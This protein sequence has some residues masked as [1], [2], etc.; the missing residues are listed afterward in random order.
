MDALRA[1]AFAKY[2]D[3]HASYGGLR[4]EFH[5]R[6]AAFIR[7]QAQ[8]NDRLREA[9]SIGS[10]KDVER[11]WSYVAKAGPDECW[12]W[13]GFSKRCGYGQIQIGGQMKR[14]HRAV[15]EIVHGT[16]LTSS[17]HVLHSCD[18]PLCVNPAHLS[19]GTT[20]DNFVDMVKKG[21]HPRCRT[22][23]TREKV[24]QIRSLKGKLTQQQIADQFG[25]SP[26]HISRILSGKQWKSVPC[27]T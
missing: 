3:E 24:A 17:E 13:T 27:A 8:E 22:F 19:V 1:E 23:L 25:V 7:A 16:V 26:H 6:A 20:N 9:L 14:A 2:H 21:R 10:Q 5:E 12:K 18:T 11:F 15:W 4:R